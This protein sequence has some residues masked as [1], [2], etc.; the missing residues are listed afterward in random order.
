MRVPFKYDY[1]DLLTVGVPFEAF[2]ITDAGTGENRFSEEILFFS[3]NFRLNTQADEGGVDITGFEFAQKNSRMT[4]VWAKDVYE[5]VTITDVLYQTGTIYAFGDIAGSVVFADDPNRLQAQIDDLATGIAVAGLGHKETRP[6]SGDTDLLASGYKQE[7]FDNAISQSNYAAYF[8]KYGHMFNQQHVDAGDADLSASSTLFYPTPIPG[9]HYRSGMPDIELDSSTDVYDGGSRIQL[10]NTYITQSNTR[11]GTAVIFKADFGTLPTGLAEGTIYYIL[12]KVTDGELTIHPT[13]VDAI[14]ATNPIAY[15]DSGSGTFRLTQ[16]GIAIDDAGQRLTGEL[17][18]I[19]A[20]P[21]QPNLEGVF[22]VGNPIG[23]TRGGGVSGCSSTLFDSANSPD[24]RT[25]NETRGAA[26]YEFNYWKVVSSTSNG[27]P[28]DG[29]INQKIELARTLWQGQKI[30][31]NHGLSD[32]NGRLNTKVEIRKTETG[33]LWQE[34]KVVTYDAAAPSALNAGCGVTEVDSQNIEVNT[35]ASGISFLGYL[36]GGLV[37][38][39]V[40]TQS[41]DIRITCSRITETLTYA[42]PT[43]RK[44]VLDGVTETHTFL[45]ATTTLQNQKVYWECTNGGELLFATASGQEIG[46]LAA[47]KWNGQ[48]KGSMSV[49]PVAGNYA[50]DSYNDYLGDVGSSADWLSVGKAKD[51]TYS[52]GLID[53]NADN[54]TE[55]AMYDNLDSVHIEAGSVF[56]VSGGYNASS[57]ARIFAAVKKS[58]AVTYSFRTL[59]ADTGTRDNVNVN[60]TNT[61]DWNDTNNTALS[62]SLVGARWQ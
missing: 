23:S 21:D 42:E 11:A 41:A 53:I 24:A 31:F 45:D 54:K 3:E 12:P 50:V 56:S 4:T 22:T 9:G 10:R 58:D 32:T 61:G 57:S 33:G 40:D 26:T 51:G 27:T 29:L 44:Y 18:L 39:L 46:G 49:D 59:K 30:L 8:A 20:T 14:A 16:E 17:A 7:A 2:E 37:N 28:I 55:S 62:I 48:G 52:S 15:T 34:L 13:E 47:N 25:S 60:S 19:A 35:G 38:L 36:D 1:R 5:A 6:T 43:T